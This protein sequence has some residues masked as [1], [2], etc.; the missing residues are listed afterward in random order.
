MSIK[1]ISFEKQNIGGLIKATKLHFKW[2]G[3]LNGTL[4][5]IEVLWSKLSGRRRIFKD[6]IQIC[7]RQLFEAA[8]THSFDVLEH[9]L[10]IMQHGENYDLRIDNISFNHLRT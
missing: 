6:G 7:E 2:R 5:T 10:T 1:P 8:F 4:T 3:H 9:R